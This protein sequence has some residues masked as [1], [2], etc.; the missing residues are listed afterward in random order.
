MVRTSNQFGKLS[1]EELSDFESAKDK[2]LPAFYLNFLLTHN[3]GQPLKQH[4]THPDTVVTYILGM[5]NGEHYA[6]LYKYI[7]M[8]SH[9][10]PFDTFP[11]AADALGNLFIMSLHPESHGQIFFWDHEKEP[12]VQVGH[13]IENTSFVAYSFEEF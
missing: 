12:A 2:K 11:I 10:L 6:S 5:H 9:R 8:F 13:Q 7:D 3:G 1:E 4:N